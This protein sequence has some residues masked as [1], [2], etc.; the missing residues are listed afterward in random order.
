MLPRDISILIRTCVEFYLNVLNLKDFFGKS[1]K[2]SIFPQIL[3]F[4]TFSQI[5]WAIFSKQQKMCT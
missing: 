4:L 2:N 3:F 1:F 5:F